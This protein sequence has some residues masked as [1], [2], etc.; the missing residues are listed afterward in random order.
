MSSVTIASGIAGHSIFFA[1]PLFALVLSI[2]YRRTRIFILLI[3]VTSI[4]AGVPLPLTSTLVWTLQACLAVYLA[5]THRIYIASLG[6]LVLAGTILGLIPSV[7]PVLSPL[8][9]V[10]EATAS[11]PLICYAFLADDADNVPNPVLLASQILSLFAGILHICRIDAVFLLIANTLLVLS[12][13]CLFVAFMRQPQPTEMTIP[14][15]IPVNIAFTASTST[16]RLTFPDTT[17][18]TNPAPV[19]LFT[20]NHHH[21]RPKPNIIIPPPSSVPGST[22]TSVGMETLTGGTLTG[23]GTGMSQAKGAHTSSCTSTLTSTASTASPVSPTSPIS[24]SSSTAS[25]LIT[26]ENPRP[27]PTTPTPIK[28]RHSFDA[29]VASIESFASPGVFDIDVDMCAGVAMRRK[30]SFYDEQELEL[31]FFASPVLQRQ[32]QKKSS[33]EGSPMPPSPTISRTSTFVADNDD[34]PTKSVHFRV[35]SSPTTSRTSIHTANTAVPVASS[36]NTN[37]TATI[38]RPHAHAHPPSA[39]NYFPAPSTPPLPRLRPHPLRRDRKPGSTLRLSSFFT[40]NGNG[41]GRWSA[42][43]RLRDS[44][45][46]EGDVPP[47]TRRPST[48]NGKDKDKEEEKEWRDDPDPFAAVPK[49]VTVVSREGGGVEMGVSAGTRMSAWGRLVL[50]AP[51]PTANTS[52]TSKSPHSRSPVPNRNPN[53]NATPLPPT[54]TSPIEPVAVEDA[55]LAQ[56]LLKKLEGRRS[57]SFLAGTGKNKEREREGTV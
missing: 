3:T 23:T 30:R 54:P 20:V 53:T 31:D 37:V 45:S 24:F 46:L 41:S 6:A 32:R 48:A 34:S 12:I 11:I 16:T 52:P 28:R 5:T 56:K 15:T 44:S 4:L 7:N 43:E 8:F 42:F 18:A 49:R 1:V 21:S 26:P 51:A 17:L 57:M 9:F 35:D 47:Q 55:L 10:L 29:D 27:L 36:T 2:L 22:L 25:T 33:C 50:P 38:T 13:G 39:Y 40:R 14:T 19:R